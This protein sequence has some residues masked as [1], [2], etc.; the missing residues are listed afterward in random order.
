MRYLIISGSSGQ[1]NLCASIQQEVV[2]GAADGGAEVELLALDGIGRCKACNE[3]LGICRN[4]HRCAFGKDGFDDARETANLADALCIVTPVV[5]GEITELVKNFL[6][7]MRRCDYGVIGA[8]AGKPM[9][10]IAAPEGTGNGLLVCLEQM[11]R[12]CRH[13]GSVI[14]DFIGVYRWNND[15]QKLSAYHAAKSM[16]YGRRAGEVI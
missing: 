5:W 11:D 8:L 13:T 4:E 6:E 12:F 3:G 1:N 16:A 15:Y 7:R 14:F 10:I 9:L 2:R